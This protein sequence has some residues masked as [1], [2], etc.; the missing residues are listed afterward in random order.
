MTDDNTQLL[1]WSN[2]DNGVY[3]YGTDGCHLCTLAHDWLIQT[4]SVY[5]P[6]CLVHHIDI[7]D[8]PHQTLQD[9]ANHIPII[10]YQNQILRYPFGIMDIVK[11]LTQNQ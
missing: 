7:I 1:I 10:V 9:I 8:L 11:L 5:H 4:I 3:L 2:D 6:K